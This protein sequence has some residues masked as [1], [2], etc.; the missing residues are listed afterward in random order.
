MRVTEQPVV[1]SG[2]SGFIALHIVENLLKSGYKVK[3]TVRNVEAKSNDIIK[4]LDSDGDKLELFKAN[5]LDEGAFDD[6]VKGCEYVLHVASPFMVDVEDAQRDLVDPAL[7]GTLSMLEACFQSESV[8]KVVLTS[9]VV[10]MTDSPN[11]KI[12]YTENDWNNDSSLTRNP[13]DYS[14]KLAEEAAW[15]FMKEKKPNFDL[16]VIN[17]SFVFGPGHKDSLSESQS[18]LKKI[19]SGEFPMVLDL[20]WSAVDVRDV[21]KAHIQLM[22]NSKANGRYI[23]ASESLDLKDLCVMLSKHFPEYSAK[24]PTMDATGFF[25]TTLATI[26]SY[27][28]PIGMG[29]YLRTNLGMKYCFDNSKIKNELNIEFMSVEDSIKD[30]IQFFID[31]DLIKKNKK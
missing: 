18:V 25:G 5:L 9:S 22:E 6:I 28:Q 14:K 12:T 27:F 10:A 2:A 16:V 7:K 15:K 31:K 19:L 20:N 26:L 24:V 21:A 13:Y 1:V 11:P 17:P 3:G 8:K 30:S 4:K 23:C 29:S